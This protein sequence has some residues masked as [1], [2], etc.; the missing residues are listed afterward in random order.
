MRDCPKLRDFVQ[1]GFGQPLT[2]LHEG[3]LRVCIQFFDEFLD[4]FF[5]EFFDEFLDEFFDE[6]L[7]NF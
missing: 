6:F 5:D 4:K 1:E 7:T 3:F 2:L